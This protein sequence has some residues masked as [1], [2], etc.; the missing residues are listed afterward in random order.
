MGQPV[1]GVALKGVFSLKAAIPEF[2]LPGYGVE[3]D[4]VG[5]VDGNRGLTYHG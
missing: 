3:A 5:V 2:V 1:G 4:G